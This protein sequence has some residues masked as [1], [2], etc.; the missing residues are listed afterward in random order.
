MENSHNVALMAKHAGLEERIAAET[1]RPNPDTVL[2][3][4]LKKKKLKL[5]EEL[6]H[7][8]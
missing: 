5:K 4:E 8:Q 2:L 6:T 7:L 1:R 3:A